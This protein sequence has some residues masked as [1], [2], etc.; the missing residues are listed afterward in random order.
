MIGHQNN[1]CYI[2]LRKKYNLWTK[3][4]SEVCLYGKL[5]RHHKIHHT[6]L[7]QVDCH[8]SIVNKIHITKHQNMHK[9]GFFN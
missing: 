2:N 7:P 8:Q 3:S 4:G 1:I 5:V 6:W 9:I